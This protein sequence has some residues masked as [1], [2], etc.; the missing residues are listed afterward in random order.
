MTRIRRL[1]VGLGDVPTGDMGIE[2]EVEPPADLSEN[3]NLPGYR[4]RRGTEGVEAS[5]GAC[6]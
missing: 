4:R 1:V 2:P 6:A 5:A 3:T